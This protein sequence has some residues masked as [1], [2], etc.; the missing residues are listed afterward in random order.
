MAFGSFL[1]GSDS[2]PGQMVHIGGRLT[3]ERALVPL[4]TVDEASVC[5]QVEF[6]ITLARATGGSLRVMD[7][8]DPDADADRTI[9]STAD[10]EETEALLSWA[11]GRQDARQPD[12]SGG[13]LAARRA[14]RRVREHVQT[15]TYD[16]LILPGGRGDG[17]LS[18]RRLERLARRAP[19]NVVSVN[20]EAGFRNFAS[21]LLPIANGP[22]SGLATD[23][24]AAMAE[25]LEAYV[26]ILHVLPPDASEEE[27]RAAEER[28]EVA[29]ERI[30]RPETANP[31]LLESKDP[32]RTIVEQS[33]YYGLT[34][35]GAPT[36]GLLH[37]FVYGSTSRSIRDR[38]ES[39][40]LAA[41]TP[42]RGP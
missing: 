16:T 31:W 11:I 14:E 35:I 42:S 41:R 21:L 22:H 37:R 8:I 17:P 29:V 27:R 10:R 36:A 23:V 13:V 39:V 7:S 38:A 12:T 24:A 4:L 28:T 1:A 9:S 19:C 32:A 18:R 20:G 5:D 26:D 34:V 25:Q 15:G 30:G 3:G 33:A 2:R 40:V 6:A